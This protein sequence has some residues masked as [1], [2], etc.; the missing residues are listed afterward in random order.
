MF[1]EGKTTARQAE[2]LPWTAKSCKCFQFVWGTQSDSDVSFR[3]NNLACQ[4]TY[5]A[6]P[7][8]ACSC[9]IENR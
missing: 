2:P 6:M 7:V 8:H 5:V 1:R 9:D 4:L 3:A